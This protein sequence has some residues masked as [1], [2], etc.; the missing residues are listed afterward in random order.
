MSLIWQ[1]QC[2]TYLCCQRSQLNK[3]FPHLAQLWPSLCPPVCAKVLQQ[4]NCNRNPHHAELGIVPRVGAVEECIPHDGIPW[5]SRIATVAVDKVA[6]SVVGAPNCFKEACDAQ[7]PCSEKRIVPAKSLLAEP[8]VEA[9][10]GG[11][12]SI[13]GPSGCMR[14]PGV[15]RW[16]GDWLGLI[17]SSGSCGLKRFQAAAIS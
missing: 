12:S 3:K 7:R 1:W 6:H 16:L 13:E 8:K 10:P 14:R 15:N 11:M 17:T 9:V 4:L 5:L 2:A